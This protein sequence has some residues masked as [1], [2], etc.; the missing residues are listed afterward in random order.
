MRNGRTARMQTM[1]FDDFRQIKSPMTMALQFGQVSTEAKT[2]QAKRGHQG[3]HCDDRGWTMIPSLRQALN[4]DISRVSLN[5]KTVL[6]G[7][8]H[9]GPREHGWQL[10]TEAPELRFVV[11]F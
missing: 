11:C 9:N 5:M 10:S 4:R 6:L 8:K 1:M 2:S 7:A 3:S